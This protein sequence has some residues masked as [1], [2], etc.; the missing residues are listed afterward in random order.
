M[1]L[2]V[3][4]LQ[5]QKDQNPNSLFLLNSRPLISNLLMAQTRPVHSDRPSPQQQREQ[6]QVVEE[7]E[8]SLSDT[9]AFRLESPTLCLTG[10]E[11]IERAWSTQVD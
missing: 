2:S 10:E 5:I 8:S 1:L 6:Q 3:H 7:E 9:A 11:C 4:D